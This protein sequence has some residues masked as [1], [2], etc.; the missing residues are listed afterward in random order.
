MFGKDTV[1]GFHHV[2]SKPDEQGKRRGIEELK[3]V[4]ARVAVT[5][6][7]VGRSVPKR[8]QETRVKRWSKSIKPMCRWMK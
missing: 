3:Q 5:L 7:E 4:I 2:E 1:L 8:W 6:P